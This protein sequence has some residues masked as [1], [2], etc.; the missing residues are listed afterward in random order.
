MMISRNKGPEKGRI[1]RSAS[2]STFMIA[3]RL[4]T[5][6]SCDTILVLERGKLV[7]VQTPKA[8]RADSVLNS[9]AS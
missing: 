5:L 1:L 9:S 6:R 8:V 4:S 7:E 3:H 2:S